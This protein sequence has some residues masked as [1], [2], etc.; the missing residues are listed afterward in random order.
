M[1]KKEIAKEKE[2]MLEI[3]DLHVKVGATPILKGI[4]RNINTVFTKKEKIN[5]YK[6]Q[7]KRSFIEVKEMI[8]DSDETRLAI[9]NKD[10]ETFVKN[11][12]EKIWSYW[13]TL[14]V[15]IK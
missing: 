10:Y 9:R 8:D 11:V 12:D 13:D 2:A 15:Y 5:I 4:N 1:K 14:R 6:Q 7:L 3:K